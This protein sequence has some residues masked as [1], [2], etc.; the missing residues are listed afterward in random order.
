MVDGW[1]QVKHRIQAGDSFGKVMNNSRD[2]RATYIL[3]P[4]QINLLFK[5]ISTV[6]LRAG[7]LCE[8]ASLSASNFRILEKHYPISK[9]E[10]HEIVNIMNYFSWITTKDCFEDTFCRRLCTRKRKLKKL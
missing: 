10:K 6:T 4:P 5:T 2:Q 3:F 9:R 7:S 1:G 8:L